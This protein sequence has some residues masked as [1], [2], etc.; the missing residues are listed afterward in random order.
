MWNRIIFPSRNDSHDMRHQCFRNDRSSVT[1]LKHKGELKREKATASDA[2]NEEIQIHS[3]K[4]VQKL[5]F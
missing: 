1:I 3:S 2:R 5:R 4:K